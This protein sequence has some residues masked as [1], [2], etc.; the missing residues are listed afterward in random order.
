MNETMQYFARYFNLNFSVMLAQCTKGL[1]NIFVCG[2][3]ATLILLN[4]VTTQIQVSKE[5]C[6]AAEGTSFVFGKKL[7]PLLGNNATLCS[8][9]DVD[10]CRFD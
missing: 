5:A 8:N 2:C 6:N 1:I 4:C 3:H 10:S 7:M 9:D